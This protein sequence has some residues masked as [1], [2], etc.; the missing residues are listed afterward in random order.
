MSRLHQNLNSSFAREILETPNIKTLLSQ[1]NNLG[2]RLI[3]DILRIRFWSN[4][5]RLLEEFSF[6]NAQDKQFV[7]ALINE[8][9]Q[10][11]EERL[12]I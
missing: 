4:E 3:D 7:L 10:N 5:N 12:S 9:L 11:Y 2:T 8:Y 1:N 6:I